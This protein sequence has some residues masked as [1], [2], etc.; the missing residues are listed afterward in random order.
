MLYFFNGL[1]KLPFL[2]LSIFNFWGYQD[3]NLSQPTVIYRAWSDGMEVQ[4]GLALYGCQWLEPFLIWQVK[5][6]AFCLF[7]VFIR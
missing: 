5:L 7:Y 4:A 3:E 6:L 2:E 1:V